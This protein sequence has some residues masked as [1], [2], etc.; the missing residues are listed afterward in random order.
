MRKPSLSWNEMARL[1]AV[2]TNGS[3]VMG[4]DDDRRLIEM[5]L[6]T[7]GTRARTKIEDGR[8]SEIIVKPTDRL[9]NFH[10]TTD[11]Q[12]DETTFIVRDPSDCRRPYIFKDQL[13]T[14]TG[15]MENTIE[16]MRQARRA[17][18]WKYVDTGSDASTG[19]MASQETLA[20]DIEKIEPADLVNIRNLEVAID[21]HLE[22]L[23]ALDE[24]CDFYQDMAELRTRGEF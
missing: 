8:T 20:V 5:D 14:L 24:N 22:I 15:I 17:L 12:I 9:R 10:L 4:A 2:V 7:T 23:G 1:Q 13:V 19:A 16:Q 18:V 11:G 3:M 6:L 21:Y